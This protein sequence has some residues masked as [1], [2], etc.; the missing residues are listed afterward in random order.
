MAN[1]CKGVGDILFSL[2]TLK[3]SLTMERD[4]YNQEIITRYGD[5]MLIYISSFFNNPT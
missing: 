3:S 1:D 4:Q 2:A 5:D